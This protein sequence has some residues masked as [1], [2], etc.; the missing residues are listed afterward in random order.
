MIINNNLCYGI[1]LL[2]NSHIY[3]NVTS[4]YWLS[5]LT[6]CVVENNFIGASLSSCSNCSF[7]NNAFTTDFTFPV[8]SN[9]G[10]KNLM[11]QT[12]Q[13]TFEVNDLSLPKNLRIRTTSPCKNAG[14]D[15]TDIGIFG[16]PAPYKPG[17][18]PFNPHIT[19]SA[20]SAQTDKDGNLKVNIQVSAQT[21]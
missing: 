9:T 5:G 11:N 19:Q 20:I 13:Q 21:R 2:I 18:V 4:S 12:T 3:N 1:S 15:G 6:E 14:T 16:G 10:S 7:N 8:G 17:A